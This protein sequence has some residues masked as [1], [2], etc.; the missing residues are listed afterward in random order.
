MHRLNPNHPRLTAGVWAVVGFAAIC[1][2]A[3]GA[4]A[5]GAGNIEF[6]WYLLIIIAA[7]AIVAVAHWSVGL[8]TPL[9]ALLA[10]MGA[11][12]MAGGLVP[13]PHS[14]PVEDQQVLYDLWLIPGRFKYDQLVHA[15]GYGVV[16]WLWWQYLSALDDEISPTLGR[17]LICAL[18]SI[19]LGAANEMAEFIANLTLPQTNVGG[20]TNTGWDLVA[21]FTGA[22]VAAAII[23]FADWRRPEKRGMHDPQG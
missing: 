7:A 13:V 5:I 1:I 15:L 3:A 14:W 23:W 11:M 2:G 12:H 19:G 8:T 16:T 18:A 4:G 9:L 21:N 17:M 20:Y 10:I 6:I 22:V